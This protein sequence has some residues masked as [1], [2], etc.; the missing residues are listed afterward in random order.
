[1]TRGAKAVVK[2]VMELH[3]GWLFL[4]STHLQSQERINEEDKR[5]TWSITHTL[6]ASP[7]VTRSTYKPH[8]SACT[9]DGFLTVSAL[10]CRI[11]LVPPTCLSTFRARLAFPIWME[12]SPTD[13]STL[14]S[15]CVSRP[16]SWL[17][18]PWMACAALPTRLRRAQPS[19]AF[20]F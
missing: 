6:P 16:C 4:A 13:K 8:V 15:R 19:R 20:S 18:C 14:G 7:A 17:P 3:L 9:V 11:S 2:G 1:M 12:N 5:Y 10:T